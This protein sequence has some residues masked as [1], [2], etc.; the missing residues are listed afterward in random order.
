[1]KPVTLKLVGTQYHAARKKALI[2]GF[3]VGLEKV[4]LHFQCSNFSRAFQGSGSFSCL[5]QST[6]SIWHTVDAWEP[7]KKDGIFYQHTSTHFSPSSLLSVAWVGEKPHITSFPWRRRDLYHLSNIPTLSVWGREYILLSES[8]GGT[9]YTLDAL[10]SLKTKQAISTGMKFKE[11]RV[12]GWANWWGFSSGNA[13]LWRLREVA[14][15]FF[16]LMHIH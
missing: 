11:F 13:S 10:E 8:A 14:I 4:G 1:M 6:D 5:S 9:W 15:F 2:P 16:F 12:S 3:C 7:Q